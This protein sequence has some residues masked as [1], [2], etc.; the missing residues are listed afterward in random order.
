MWLWLSLS[1]SAL[2]LLVW[3][4]GWMKKHPSSKVRK[5][6]WWVEGAMLVLVLLGV[7]FVFLC[8]DIIIAWMT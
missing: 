5:A 1:M 4:D 8:Q 2:L 3:L 7:A 6:R